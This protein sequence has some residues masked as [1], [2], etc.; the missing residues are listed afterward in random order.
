M[1]SYPQTET[2]AVQDIVFTPPFAYPF[3][4]EE[5]ID[6]GSNT[7]TSSD[8]SLDDGEISSSV[9][10]VYAPMAHAMAGVSERLEVPQGV[11]T[12]KITANTFV[13]NSSATSLSAFGFGYAVSSLFLNIQGSNGILCEKE[14][15]LNSSMSPVIWYHEA[16]STQVQSVTC[17]INVFT[18][19]NIIITT[20]NKSFSMG[21]VVSASNASNDSHIENINVE[22]LN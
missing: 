4:F 10:R 3:N 6:Y 18:E 2:P 15:E 17:T 11:R 7:S 22:I 13:E 20:G 21:L 16:S 5:Y 19:S 12:L 14:Y 9:R 8:V 1:E